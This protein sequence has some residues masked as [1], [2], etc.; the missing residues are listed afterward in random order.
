MLI[1]TISIVILN[2]AWFMLLI[3][4]K[5]FAFLSGYT[6]T[7]AIYSIVI[8]VVISLF[9][10]GR[11]FLKCW[12]L[13]TINEQK[14]KAEIMSSR[15]EALKNQVNPHFLFNSLNV[16]T[17]LVYKDQDLAARFIKKL[18]DVYRYVLLNKDLEVVPLTEELD[19]V[20]DFVFLQQIRY[21]KGLV[22][23]LPESFA[24][25]SAIPPLCIQMLV[26]N[27]LKHNIISEEDPL[28]VDIQI[29]EDT[30]IVKN[31]LQVKR[32]IEEGSNTGL[33]NIKERIRY[34]SGKEIEV[35]NDGH[36]FIV[37][38]PLMELKETVAK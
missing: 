6:A 11:S 27:A 3:L 7:N 2:N 4:K 37:K 10:H 18:A 26:E 19:F 9:L 36:D 17:A 33:S 29:Q 23:K 30:I 34:L 16:L 21:D 38:L 28:T 8:T 14:L 1:Y 31:N 20:K 5:D 22:V 15:Y 12:R 13:S 25:G 24:S 35:I 32:A